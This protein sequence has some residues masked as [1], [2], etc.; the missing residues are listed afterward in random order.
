VEVGEHG[1]VYVEVRP[2][3]AGYARHTRLRDNLTTE[4]DAI[5]GRGLEPDEDE[6]YENDVRKVIFRD[7]DGNQVGL[8][9]DI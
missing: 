6:T 3:H 8:A 4:L 1:D 9:G 2:G 7:P 5:A